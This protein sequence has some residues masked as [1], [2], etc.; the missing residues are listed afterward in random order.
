MSGVSR[1]AL[2][3]LGKQNKVFWT[4]FKGFISKGNI[5]NL[6]IGVVIGGAFSSVVT[7]LV[8][9][10]VMPF[11]GMFTKG[12]DFSRLFLDLTVMMEKVPVVDA[13]TAPPPEYLPIQVFATAQQ[14]IDAGHVVISYGSLLTTAINFLIIAF[15]VF[16]IVRSLTKMSERLKKQE[17]AKE[18]A[19]E[20]AVAATEKDCPFCCQRI[21]IPAT[22]CPFCTSE[23]PAEET[24]ANLTPL[25]EG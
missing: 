16:L 1:K 18:A 2:K 15:V 10:V 14:A 3:K 4:D 12:V 25:P 23:L 7:A 20:A 6:A 5:I 17:E 13:M 22:R 9:D 8:N 21:P 19:A 11:V 24:P